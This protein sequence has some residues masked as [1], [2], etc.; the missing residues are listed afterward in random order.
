MH[1]PTHPTCSSQFV[2]EPSNSYSDFSFLAVGLFMMYCGWR[3]LSTLRSMGRDEVVSRYGSNWFR[4]H[5]LLSIA[6]GAMNCIHAVGTAYNHACRCHTGHRVDCFG[7]FGI[8]AFVSAYTLLRLVARADGK[9]GRSGVVALFLALFGLLLVPLWTI[10][11]DMYYPLSL[12]QETRVFIMVLL[13]VRTCTNMSVCVHHGRLTRLFVVAT[14]LCVLGRQLCALVCTSGAIPATLLPTTSVWGL[15]WAC[16]C[17]V[18][19][20][21]RQTSATSSAGHARWCRGMP[22][23]TW[24]MPWCWWSP[25]NTFAA[26]VGLA[27]TASMTRN[28]IRV[29]PMIV[30]VNLI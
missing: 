7:M 5:P 19:S 26:S 11:G 10:T 1:P 13:P 25:T 28:L 24:A 16:C 17:C 9:Q 18:L 30:V 22:C 3:D 4:L 14:S 15:P 21:R 2:R 27:M 20:C 23:G 12:H 8:I 29:E 6:N